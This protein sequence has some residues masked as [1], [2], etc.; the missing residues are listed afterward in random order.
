MR[1]LLVLAAGTVGLL[2]SA[3]TP[4]AAQSGSRWSVW[5]GMDVVSFAG[6]A[7]EDNTADAAVVRPARATG[8]NLGVGRRAGPWEVQLELHYSQ[9]HLTA[10]GADAAI[11]VRSQSYNRLGGALMLRRDLA[12]FD[13]GALF[14]ALGP[15]VDHWSNQPDAE[16][17]VWG[18]KAGV[19]LRLEA[20]GFALENLFTYG[21]SGNPVQ[22]SALPQGGVIRSFRAATFGT[23]VRVGL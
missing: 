10:V 7:A 5:V 2:A 13:R 6:G 14:L 19:G 20:G 22:P 15:T 23:R 11:E 4:A 3:A 21:I 17:T 1:T 12:R 8:M 9:T 16:G 18:G